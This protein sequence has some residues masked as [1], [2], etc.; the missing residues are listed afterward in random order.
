MMMTTIIIYMKIFNNRRS[1]GCGFSF[2][3]HGDD[4][5]ERMN[6]DKMLR[7]NVVFNCFCIAG[8]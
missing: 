6:K 4:D 3:Q 5:K 7:P 1:S 8:D 2:W